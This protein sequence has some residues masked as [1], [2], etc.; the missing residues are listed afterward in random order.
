[1]SLQSAAP[2]S[3]GGFAQVL[4]V[5]LPFITLCFV[6][7]PPHQFSSPVIAVVSVQCKSVLQRF[8]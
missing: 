1:M 4:G 8:G 3:Q 2:W 7:L 5:S 6:L